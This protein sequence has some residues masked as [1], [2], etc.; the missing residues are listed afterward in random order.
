MKQKR[1]KNP[2]PQRTQRT[3]RKSKMKRQLPNIA[4][5]HC[6]AAVNSRPAFPFRF[7]NGLFFL[8]VL[9]V[10]CGEASI[11]LF[12][13]AVPVLA[14]EQADV[15]LHHGKI[16]TVDDYFTVAQALAI[17]GERVIATG[18]NGEIAKLAG[19]GTRKIDLKGR[20]V[21]PGLI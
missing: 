3:Q 15:I 13:S 17:K 9:G 21:I 6:E 12:T 2:E 16:V 4:K 5:T 18:S 10:L 7:I 20:T 8:R 1:R 11:L 19:P 14:A